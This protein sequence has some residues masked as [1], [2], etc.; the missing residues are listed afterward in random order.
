M[1]IK[2]SSSIKVYDVCKVAQNESLVLSINMVS[3]KILEVMLGLQLSVLF[4][5]VFMDQNTKQ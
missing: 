5:T 1:T 2:L 3:L 4:N